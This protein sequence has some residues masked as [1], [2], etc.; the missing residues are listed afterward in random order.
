MAN[1]FANRPSVPRRRAIPR[2]VVRPSVRLLALSSFAEPRAAS[3]SI[4]SMVM[5]IIPTMMS[6]MSI[7]FMV[8]SSHST[9]FLQY[10]SFIIILI[11]RG[12]AQQEKPRECSGED[13]FLSRNPFIFCMCLSRKDK[14]AGV[15]SGC[16]YEDT[17]G[18]SPV[19]AQTDAV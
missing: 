15:F 11:F 14:K 7:F 2:T 1:S 5:S 17:D 12:E 3:A 10:C 18:V 19:S 13:F 8:F 9:V 6:P 16:W 4:G